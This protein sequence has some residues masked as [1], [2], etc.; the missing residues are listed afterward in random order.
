LY[1]Y[2]LSELTA[3]I[4]IGIIF[5]IK[6]AIVL[7]F[8]ETMNFF[9]LGG[10]NINK[11]TK[12]RLDLIQEIEEP[13]SNGLEKYRQNG[14]Q[15]TVLRGMKLIEISEVPLKQKYQYSLI[16]PVYNEENTIGSIIEDLLDTFGKEYEIIIVDDH[17]KDASWNIIK[18][19]DGIRKF[20]LSRN[21]G[22]GMAIK[23]GVKHS[24]GKSV[25]FLDSDG[26]HPISEVKKL[27]DVHQKNRTSLIIGDRSKNEHYTT[28]VNKV[29]NKLYS[30]L[31]WLFTGSFVSDVH[32]GLRVCDN[33][34]FINLNIKS[35]RY[36]FELE[37][38]FKWLTKYQ[39]VID[40]D[41]V[42]PNRLYGRS[43]MSFFKDN[44]KMFLT[45]L[46]LKLSIFGSLSSIFKM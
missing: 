28:P 20:R 8:G 44:I 32:S 21:C 16:V 26:S 19:Y 41:I 9:N 1:L 12:T 3:T 35:N 17:S 29:G 40:V 2:D 10:K 11:F 27:I 30:I 5:T 39:K 42:S 46:T 36:T 23:T 33:K 18:Q 34:Q 37:L 43:G 45:I 6:V 38:L 31:I 4:T 24:K 22:K 7:K 13:T 25:V 14:H 15:R